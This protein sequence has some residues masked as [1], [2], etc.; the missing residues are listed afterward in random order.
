[1]SED[2][3][4]DLPRKGARKIKASSII[5]LLC[6]YAIV[7]WGVLQIYFQYSANSV[8]WANALPE[9]LNTNLSYLVFWARILPVLGGILAVLLLFLGRSSWA[10]IYTGIAFS[11][12]MVVLM[13]DRALVVQGLAFVAGL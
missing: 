12:G 7:G 1:M 9:P 8:L 10:A 3:T 4:I 2:A 11:H 5:E 13:T 6:F